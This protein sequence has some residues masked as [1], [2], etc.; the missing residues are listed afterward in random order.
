MPSACLS[1]DRGEHAGARDRPVRM[2]GDA[3]GWGV[4][5]AAPA[6][7]LAE[8]SGHRG[9]GPLGC[10]SPCSPCLDHT[11][12]SPPRIL[13][14]KELCS[15]GPSPE[16]PC[17]PRC[18]LVRAPCWCGVSASRASRDTGTHASVPTHRAQALQM[19]RELTG[20]PTA[21]LPEGVTGG[22]HSCA[23]QFPVQ[24]AVPCPSILS[25]CP[26]RQTDTAQGQRQAPGALR[27]GCLRPRSAPASG[28]PR[29]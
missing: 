11:P 27:G 3:G 20:S 8:D 24:R 22:S 15:C 16:T 12:F 10:I 5:L 17:G 6:H 21:L 25:S 29:R 4:A 18:S 1:S 23:P 28:S 13:V 26:A 9:E 19:L 14:S 2:T 7:H